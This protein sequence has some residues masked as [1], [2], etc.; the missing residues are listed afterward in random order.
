[1]M[2]LLLKYQMMILLLK[3]QMMIPQKLLLLEN[4]MPLKNI[5]I[6]PILPI[7]PESKM[8]LVMECG[9]QVKW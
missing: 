3:D 9:E 1:M 2:I 7:L 6:L 5:I 8:V 4:I